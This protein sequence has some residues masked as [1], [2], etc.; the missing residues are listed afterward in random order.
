MPTEPR[1]RLLVPDPL[2]E[3]F[4]AA[5]AN[6]SPEQ[7]LDYFGWLVENRT[8]TNRLCF[9]GTVNQCGQFMMDHLDEWLATTN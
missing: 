8:E 9:S 4:D 7:I 3:T 5:F 1:G 6:R 2:P